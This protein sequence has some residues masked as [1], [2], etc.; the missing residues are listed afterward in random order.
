M[1]LFL[2][3][4]AGCLYL[5]KALDGLF[6]EE[7]HE[8]GY[9][10]FPLFFGSIIFA[11]S[12]VDLSRARF[13]ILLPVDIAL[14]ALAEFIAICEIK[15]A[16]KKADNEAAAFSENALKNLKRFKTS[17]SKQYIVVS[18][19]DSK[20][21]LYEMDNDC[22]LFQLPDGRFI[23]IL[24]K[25]RKV[26]SLLM[27]MSNIRNEAEDD[28]DVIAYVD[29]NG[30]AVSRM[31][32]SGITGEE[33]CYVKGKPSYIGFDYSLLDGAQPIVPQNTVQI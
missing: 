5:Y 22:L 11:L 3:P 4:L 24:R 32:T 30:G 8:G 7:K 17:Q 15:T 16:R 31:F 9:A 29:N 10:F 2:P 21:I 25:S 19:V 18:N 20:D 14:I 28:L 26:G 33:H 13:V 6:V 27:L 23:V 12:I 1:I